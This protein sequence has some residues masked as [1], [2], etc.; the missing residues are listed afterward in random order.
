MVT[1]R[2]IAKVSNVS[3]NTVSRVLNGKSKDIWPRAKEQ[4]DK[5][6][7]VAKKLNYSP[8]T[9]ARAMRSKKFH[10]VGIVISGK[11]TAP[12]DFEII[13][14]ANEI[15]KE[16]GYSMSVVCVDE[17]KEGYN[18]LG[19]NSFD[20][21]IIR[22]VA[23]EFRK[24]I[25]KLSLNCIWVDTNENAKECCIRRD[26]YYSGQLVASKVLDLGYKDILYVYHDYKSVSADDHYS[27]NERKKG[28]AD[29][30]ESVADVKFR[31]IALPLEGALQ[32][33]IENIFSSQLNRRTMII[34]A[35]V[36]VAEKVTFLAAA[37]GLCVGRDFALASCDESENTKQIWSAL[38][39]IR[40][41]R[42][43]MGEKAANM[44]L[45]MITEKKEKV[46]SVSI[47]G[48]WF[49]GE[50]ALVY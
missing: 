34:A 12:V 30:V 16:H 11:Y 45:S 10:R 22:H 36:H 5:I 42:G 40:L 9:A 25:K 29:E 18:I 23:A 50:T 39:R 38:S 2:D 46:P 37:R 26:E 27:R 19:E 43:D 14:G 15:F 6:R 20:G 24:E 21:I 3:V 17:L 47:R 35:D 31:T 7:K 41:D 44:L 49:E 28:V 33:N 1:L 32:D 48:E 4:A 8:N 13:M